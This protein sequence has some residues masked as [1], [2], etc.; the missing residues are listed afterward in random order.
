MV[1][2]PDFLPF[3]AIFAIESSAAWYSFGSQTLPYLLP[4]FSVLA[5]ST[6]SRPTSAGSATGVAGRLSF[7]CQEC[8]L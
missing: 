2:A 5:M 4:P 8:D 6:C 3:P 1:K 7:K